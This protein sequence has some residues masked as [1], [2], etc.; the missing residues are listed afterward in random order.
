MALPRPHSQNM[1]ELGLEP[2]LPSGQ[3]APEHP[4][5]M[6]PLA[7]DLEKAPMPHFLVSIEVPSCPSHCHAD[8]ALSQ[9]VPCGRHTRCTDPGDSLVGLVFCPLSQVRTLR[10][11]GVRC[12]PRLIQRGA[13]ATWSQAVRSGAPTPGYPPPPHGGSS[14]WLGEQL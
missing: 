12:L 5:L 7:E 1:E 2:A 8:S 3:G 9:P 10:L 6:G 4:A 14:V 13:G 11:R